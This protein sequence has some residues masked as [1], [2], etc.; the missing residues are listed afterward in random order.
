MR[1][2]DPRTGIEV[3]DRDE[4]LQL[5]RSQFVGR[6]AVVEDGTPMILPVNYAMDADTIVF[7]TAEGTKFDAAVRGGPVA[8]EIDHTDPV[9][10]IGW[11]VVVTGHARLITD[12][13]GLE[14][15]RAL[16]LRPWSDH[17]KSNW[18]GIHA[19]GATGRR[20]VSVHHAEG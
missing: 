4:C 20:I 15:A 17:A 10:Q 14:R 16:P 13:A 19:E 9:Y 6:L 1:L 7:R 3:L 18:V 11:S 12:E 2:I 8:F 5:L